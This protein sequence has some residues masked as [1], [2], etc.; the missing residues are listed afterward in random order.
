MRYGRYC[1]S[2]NWKRVVKWS[3]KVLKCSFDVRYVTTWRSRIV[4]HGPCSNSKTANWWCPLPRSSFH[5]GFRQ[6][7]WPVLQTPKKV[8]NTNIASISE[9]EYDLYGLNVVHL[10]HFC[11]DGWK[12]DWE[13]KGMGLWEV[14]NLCI[15]QLQI[16]FHGRHWNW[17][18]PVT[19]SKTCPKTWW[20]MNVKLQILIQI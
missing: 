17:I 8:G 12:N 4:L 11:A 19:L 15:L 16:L 20:W 3:P 14:R 7:L 13:P 10:T 5:V 18:I 1:A 6:I 2:Q 9:K